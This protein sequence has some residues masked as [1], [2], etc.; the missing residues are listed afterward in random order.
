MAIDLKETRVDLSLK[1]FENLIKQLQG[2]VLKSN[3]RDHTA[4]L[5]LRFA[6][7]PKAVK[8]WIQTFAREN[9]TST[10][11]QMEDTERFRKTRE[12]K[13]FVTS[14]S[15]LTVTSTWDLM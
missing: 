5:F 15:R 7:Q 13:L 14:T 6:A 12:S 3:G 4:H 8:Q 1:K 10:K 2:G 11:Q 9:L